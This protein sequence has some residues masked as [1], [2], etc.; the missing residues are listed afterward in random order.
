[1]GKEFIN[2]LA[3]QTSNLHLTQ[4]GIRER[5]G[6]G[7]P[8]EYSTIKEE[9]GESTKLMEGSIHIQDVDVNNLK[10][11]LPP[12]NFALSSDKYSTLPCGEINRK[13]RA[14]STAKA[15]FIKDEQYQTVREE[16]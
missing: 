3:Q 13:K 12:P 16:S 9:K 1:M 8:N 6:G 15:E 10:V 5:G 2:T 4:M 11:D 14:K 7:M